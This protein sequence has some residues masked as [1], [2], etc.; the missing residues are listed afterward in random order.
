MRVGCLY[1]PDLPLQALL[2]A[3][4][5]LVGNPVAVARG[6]GTRAR[7]VSV[8]LQ[9]R[10]QGARPG[11]SIGDA[12]AFCPSLVVRWAS[13]DLEASAQAAISSAVGT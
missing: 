11:Q 3:E 5:T 1:V 2:R 13:P 12:L 10:T 7:L 6:E 8:S 4:P 9:A